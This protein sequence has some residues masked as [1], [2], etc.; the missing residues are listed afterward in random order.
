MSESWE[1]PPGLQLTSRS[2]HHVTSD[3]PCEDQI[4]PQ[5]NNPVSQGHSCART[6]SL[7]ARTCSR[8]C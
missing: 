5:K 8:L 7:K 6:P 2:L 3:L 4:D 1:Q